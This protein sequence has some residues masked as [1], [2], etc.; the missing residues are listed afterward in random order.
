MRNRR[1]EAKFK[2]VATYLKKYYPEV[3][4]EVFD[5]MQ[6]KTWHQ[7]E[8]MTKELLSKEENGK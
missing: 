4:K 3:F 2:F 5:L 7:L 1:L 6:G 8:E